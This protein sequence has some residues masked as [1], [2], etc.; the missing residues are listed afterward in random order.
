MPLSIR[1]R[2]VGY[3]IAFRLLRIHWLLFRP[4]VRG[5][6]CLLTDGELVLLVRHTYGDRRWDLPGGTLHRHEQP[7]AAAR[8]EMAEELGVSIPSW[9]SLGELHDRVDHRRDELHCFQAEVH[10]PEIKLDLGE[11]SV[12]LW[13][14]RHHLP[15]QLARYVRPILARSARP[16]TNF[17][18]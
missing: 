3:R 13:F 17:R 14:P 15:G 9:T 7:E 4:A 11:L 8:R 16:A 2:R 6:K 12:A 10:E 5:V 18:N 1:V